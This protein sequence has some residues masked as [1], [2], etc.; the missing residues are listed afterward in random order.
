MHIESLKGSVSSAEGERERK[1]NVSTRGK[2][3]TASCSRVKQGV[4]RL[5]AEKLSYNQ[6]RHC[7]Q[8]WKLNSQQVTLTPKKSTNETNQL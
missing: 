2:V 3:K 7:P 8:M 4:H 1:M 6:R 5:T